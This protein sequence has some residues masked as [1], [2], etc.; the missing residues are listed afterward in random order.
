MNLLFENLSTFLQN[1]HF[2]ACF[3]DALLKSFLV[4]ALAGGVCALARRAAAATRHLVWFL[5][6]ASLPCLPLLTSMLPTWEKPLW[7]V[8]TGF[9]SGNQ[10][11]LALNFSPVAK[12]EA[13]APQTPAA[14]N[15]AK[16]SGDGNRIIATRFNANWL[17]FGFA[18]W[19]AGVSLVLISVA[20]GQFRL[21]Q[22]SCN[23]QPLDDAEWTQLL[24]EARETLCLPQAV[25]LLQSVDHVMPM[26]WG[27]LRPVVLL[28]AESRYWPLERRRI[29]LL[30]ELAHVKRWDCLT[31]LA[32]KI[33][34]AF[35]WFNPLVW[36]AARQMCIERERACDDLVLNGGCKASDYAGHLVEIAGSFRRVPQVAAIAMARPS[37]LEQRVAAIVDASRTRCLRPVTL[38]AV[39]AVVGGIIFCV[40]GCKTTYVSSTA[41]EFNPLREQQI[42]RLKEFSTLKEKQSQTLAAAAGEKISPEFQRYFDAATKG[43]WQTVTNMYESFKKRHPQY[44]KKGQ[45]SNMSLRTS[46]W[47]P[48]LEI[49]LAYDQV[50]R[51]EPKYT[52]IAVDGIINSI[53]AGSIYFGGTDPGRGLPTAFSKSHVDAD[54]FY[55][56][57]QN[58]L[59]DRTYLEYMR[60]T[61]GEEKPLLDQQAEV[62]HADTQ[63]QA[64]DAEWP[65]AVQ[66]LD[67][68]EMDDANP[69]YQ[70]AKQAVEDLGQK[71]DERT[72]ALFASLQIRKDVSVA[73]LGKKS[74]YIP[75][76][77]DS[78]HC[79]MEYVED[80]KQRLQNHQLKPGED[81]K[82]SD[83]RTQISGQVAVMA[84][85]GLLVKIIF[86][87]NPGHEFF[88]E[89]SFPLDWMYPNL[90]P[91]G[92]IFKINRQPLT[93]LSDTMVQ[94]DRAYWQKIVPGMIGGWL[95]DDTSVQDVT[96][97]AEKV[98]L[99]HNLDGFTGDPRFVQNDYASRMFSK[100][101]SSIAGLYAR[102]ADHATAA[103]EKKRMAY[104]ADFA[105]RQ[106][107]A[108][109]PSSPE[110]V[111]RY[112][113]FLTSQHREADARLVLDMAEQFKSKSASPFAPL[114]KASFFQMRL[115]VDAPADDAEKMIRL[116]KIPAVGQVR[117]E[118]V[119]VQKSVLLDQ[120]ALQSAQLN[121]GPQGDRQIEIT[122][123]SAGRKEF[124]KV[125]REHLH[126]RLA[127]IIDGKLM[128]APTIQ[129]EISGGKCQI[130]G[131]FSEAEAKA[132]TA[133][134]NAAIAR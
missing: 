13:A 28:P 44:G 47:G 79:F 6:V 90:E 19:L 126:Q 59:A 27:W 25:T 34:C 31:Q 23:V 113:T 32:A 101:R 46:Y 102:R 132:L 71:R 30:H 57:T 73:G 16:I 24:A 84:I 118:E 36:L 106:A 20:V 56:L 35:Y 5:A 49:S 26:T 29:V 92:L 60:R 96:A 95:N 61:Y 21:R 82:I 66:K 129:S 93:E 86:D 70:A 38:L 53:P 119:Y 89:E 17:V 75:T 105:F 123:T 122:F 74:L 69:Q 81:V 78:Q 10:V 11:S 94:Q 12:S 72:K 43:D 7:S 15:G 88:V 133:K 54:P 109:C 115:V 110:A 91:H 39:L 112:T 18:A 33:V 1:S 22:F 58:A 131:S 40:S 121:T 103:A 104:A 83:G 77:E 99:Q 114:A 52:Q 50:V 128:T 8:S 45:H 124:A 64:L 85:N 4:L 111:H 62:R 37:G 65:V 87:K 127:I 68:L 100:L 107:F 3:F 42:D 120:T 41:K 76:G 14:P 117:Q 130:T 9:D 63:L 2:A 125:T 51:C 97:F 80:A 55:T 116:E 108:L 67:S 48:V 134:L 98:F